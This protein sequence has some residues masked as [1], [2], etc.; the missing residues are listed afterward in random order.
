MKKNI[1]ATLTIFIA[2][3]FF[4]AGAFGAEEKIDKS[5]SAQP[6]QT[7]LHSA[8]QFIGT[9]VR[10]ANGD[11]IGEVKDLV[12]D[13]NHGVG[14]AVV[15]DEKLTQVDKNI[16][17]PLSAFTADHAGEYVSLPVTKESLTNYPPRPVGMNDEAYGRNLYDYYGLSYPWTENEQTPKNRIVPGSEREHRL[18]PTGKPIKPG[19]GG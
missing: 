18:E 16:L 14:Y 2:G 13:F 9:Q 6:V 19:V 10:D 15:E 1:L 8:K 12:F 17:V 11:K 7:D 3:L 4:A 5:L